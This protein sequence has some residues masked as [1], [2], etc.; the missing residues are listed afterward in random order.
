MD[1]RA[2]DLDADGDLDL[3]VAMEFAA[4]VLLLNDGTG[5]FADVSAERLPRT[6]HDSEDI[7]IADFDADGDLDLVF[8]SEDDQTNEYWLNDG[9]AHFSDASDRF[10]VRGTTNAVLTHDFDGDGSPDLLLGNNGPNVLLLN[11]GQGHFHDAS[12]EWLPNRRDTTQDVELGDVD[13]DGDLDLL[14]GN[15]DAN[16][17]LLREGNRFVEA[18]EAQLPLRRSPEETREADFGDVDGDGDLDV[19]FGNINAFVPGADPQNRLL[20][21]DGRGFF[22]DVTATHLPQQATRSFDVD[23]VD[24]D[25]DGDL[26]VLTADAQPGPRYTEPFRVYRND[27]TG[28]FTEATSDLFP[29]GVV[30]KG[31]D[32][33][34]VDVNGDGKRDLYFASQ[35]SQDHLLLAR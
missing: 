22:T 10:P 13:G 32:V 11:D 34:A 33:E 9:A 3:V 27:G 26:D 23:L 7:A 14:V 28:R 25:G 18:A 17:L 1:V 2:A 21:N 5:R 30:G 4:N 12:A 6:D 16:R 31:F 24:V 20:L 19:I 29:A 15:E 35:G 8:V